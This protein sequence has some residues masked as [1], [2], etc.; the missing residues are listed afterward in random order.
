MM[1]K[2][3]KRL[4]RKSVRVPPPTGSVNV[5]ALTEAESKTSKGMTELVAD[6]GQLLLVL[7]LLLVLLSHVRGV[8]GSGV[9]GSGVVGLEPAVGRVLTAYAVLRL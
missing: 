1:M 7:V 8:V 5:I 2:R 9:V 6:P 3:L 4:T